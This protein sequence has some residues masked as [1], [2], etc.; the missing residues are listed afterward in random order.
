MKTNRT[1][2][3][4]HVYPWTKLEDSSTHLVVDW[5]KHINPK[6][7]VFLD[8]FPIDGAPDDENKRLFHVDLITQ[9]KQHLYTTY[10]D[11]HSK[12]FLKRMLLPLYRTNICRHFITTL[13]TNI[14][15]KYSYDSSNFAGNLLGEYGIKEVVPKDVFGTPRE[16]SFGTLKSFIPEKAEEYLTHVYGEDWMSLPPLEKRKLPHEWS[17]LTFDTTS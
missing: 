10:F 4:D 5:H 8:I 17:E 12:N 6:T 2:R 11:Y 13:T 15:K 7:G 3:D 1:H 16:V 9:L 14:L